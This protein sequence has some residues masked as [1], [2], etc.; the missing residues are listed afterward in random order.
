MIMPSEKEGE[1]AKIFQRR[2]I[3]FG[4]SKRSI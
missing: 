2:Y 4:P 1:I 3:R